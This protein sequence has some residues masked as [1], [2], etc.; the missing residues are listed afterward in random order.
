MSAYFLLLS[1]AQSQREDELDISQ[2][3]I[4]EVLEW[5]NGDGWCKG[6]NKL[7][8]EGFVPQSYVQLSSIPLSPPNA[9]PI[10]NAAPTTTVLST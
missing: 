6:R 4:L 2:E 3:E 7:G 10:A 9:T 1:F 5:D 8:K